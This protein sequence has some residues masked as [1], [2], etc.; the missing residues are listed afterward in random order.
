LCLQYVC[1]LLNHAYNDTLKGVLLQLLSGITIDIIPPLQF[2][3]W[4]KVYYKSADCGFLSDSV[5]IMGHVVGIS[6]HYGHALTYKVLDASTLKVFHRSL[7]RPAKPDDPNLRAESLGGEIKYVI[8][9][10]DDI[11][12]DLLVSKHLNTL[13]PPPI[14]DPDELIGRTF[15]MDAQPDG[16]QFCSRN[17]KMIEDHD[18][19]LETNKDQIKFLLSTN[20]D[21]SEEI[22]TY[23]QLLDYLAKD[24]NNEFIWKFKRIVSHQGPLT[25]K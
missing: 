21:A 12:N 18:Y 6:E 5:E 23:N 10:R 16:S 4:Q 1:Y 15:L 13:A 2:H 3:F 19:K 24:D 9:S 17:V 7:L 11:D 22:I 8:Q 20:E 25:P 14:V